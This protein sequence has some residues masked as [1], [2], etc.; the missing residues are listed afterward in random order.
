[1]DEALGKGASNWIG[2][3]MQATSG[4][5]CF[6]GAGQAA[7]SAMNTVTTATQVGGGAATA[8]TSGAHARVAKFQGDV[9]DAEA[10]TVAAQ[11]RGE[12]MTR[13]VEWLIDGIRETQKSHERAK[14]TLG[15]AIDQHGQAQKAAL[16]I[17]G[18]QLS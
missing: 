9:A 4:I 18:R 11:R 1:L 2:L 3:G 5:I 10:D 8:V 17:N 16:F 7:G 13:L 12:R 15:E 6:A 14:E